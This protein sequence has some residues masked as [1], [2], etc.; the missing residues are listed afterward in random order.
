MPEGQW[1][2]LMAAM[3]TLW[4]NRDGTTICPSDAVQ[5]VGGILARYR[6]ASRRH[7]QGHD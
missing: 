2:W 4:W 5:V 7:R 6:R 1:V 3:R